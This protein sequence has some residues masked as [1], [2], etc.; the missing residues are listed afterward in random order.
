MRDGKQTIHGSIGLKHPS[1][2][3]EDRNTPKPVFQADDA[4]MNKKSK[5]PLY[6]EYVLE[7]SGGIPYQISPLHK[8]YTRV[9]KSLIGIIMVSA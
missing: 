7:D 1:W 4:E 3:A 6:F 8:F 5:S 2:I 9:S